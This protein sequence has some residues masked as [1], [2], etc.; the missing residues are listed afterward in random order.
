MFRF[1]SP[2]LTVAVGFVLALAM[3][4]ARFVPILAGP[5]EWQH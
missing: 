4:A 3:A 2:R 5:L 1:N